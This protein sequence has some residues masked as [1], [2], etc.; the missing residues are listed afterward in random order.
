MTEVLRTSSGNGGTSSGGAAR[1]R[2]SG[3]PS[4]SAGGAMISAVTGSVSPSTWGTPSRSTE[5]GAAGNVPKISS[6]LNE[7]G[8]TRVAPSST[9]PSPSAGG[10]SSAWSTPM[11]PTGGDVPTSKSLALALFT[12]SWPA[13]VGGGVAISKASKAASASLSNMASRTGLTPMRLPEVAASAPATPWGGG[14]TSL[15]SSTISSAS[16]AISDD[17]T[18]VP[19][20]ISDDAEGGAASAGSSSP[21][22]TFTFRISSWRSKGLN[23]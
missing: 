21:T 5:A 15:A 10:A 19:R 16:M 9:Q 18:S 6:A 14:V 8:T 3:S 1:R 17:T 4:I 2:S 7:E 12:N 13:W 22:R 11:A 23:M 20:K